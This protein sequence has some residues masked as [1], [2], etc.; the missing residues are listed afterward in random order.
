MIAIGLFVPIAV[1]VIAALILIRWVAVLI[2]AIIIAVLLAA[3]PCIAQISLNDA[4]AGRGEIAALTAK[5]LQR[6]PLTNGHTGTETLIIAIAGLN[7]VGDLHS[8]E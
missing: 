7:R 3:G 8:L 5:A 4:L 6:L 2:A 1:I